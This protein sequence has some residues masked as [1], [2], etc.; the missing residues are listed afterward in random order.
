MIVVGLLVELLRLGLL[1]CGHLTSCGTCSECCA[2]SCNCCRTF[3]TTVQ[4][5]SS[6]CEQARGSC[7]KLLFMSLASFGK[8]TVNHGCAR[9]PAQQQHRPCING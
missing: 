9:I 7:R 2:S 6:L 3:L 8:P 4:I 5:S 1:R